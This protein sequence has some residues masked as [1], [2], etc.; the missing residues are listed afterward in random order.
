MNEPK[1]MVTY[2][3]QMERPQAREL[4]DP[5]EGDGQ[6]WL[7]IA[8][9]KVVAGTKRRT[10]LLKALAETDVDIPETPTLRALDAESAETHEPTQRTTTEWVIT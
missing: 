8:T 3:V 9:V 5:A 10:I 1:K 4:L 7:D 6:V 2:T